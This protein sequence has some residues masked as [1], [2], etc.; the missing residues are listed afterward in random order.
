MYYLIS[1]R[2]KYS[3]RNEYEKVW[4]YKIDIRKILM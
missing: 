2:K 1:L 3:H 4:L